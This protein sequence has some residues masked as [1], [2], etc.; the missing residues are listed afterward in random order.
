MRRLVEGLASD[1]AYC[2]M[3][4][5]SLMIRL[6]NTLLF[7]MCAVTLASPISTPALAA[8]YDYGNGDSVVIGSA[9]SVSVKSEDN[10]AT[11]A[12]QHELGFDAIVAANPGV[13][14]WFPGTGRT[15]TLP[16]QHILPDVAHEGI[17]VNLP[18]MRLYYFDSSSEKVYTYPV[19]IGRAGWETPIADTKVIAVQRNPAWHPPQSI[20]D[21][22]KEAGLSL[23]SVIP[24][25]PENP[26]GND[27]HEL[28]SHPLPAPTP[29][30]GS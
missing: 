6:F 4:D 23:P 27:L 25:G 16:N 2:L 12:L 11:L 29:S 28:T 26:L 7:S 9:Y 18:E 17:V 30:T 21:E 10:F 20:I 5:I 3:A 1:V 13:N 14:P 15:I 24:A 22:Y 19:G 8:T